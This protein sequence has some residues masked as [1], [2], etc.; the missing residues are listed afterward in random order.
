MLSWLAGREMVR[1][2]WQFTRYGLMVALVTVA[3]SMP[4]LWIR[5]FLLA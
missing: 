3:V 2:F 5:Y 4:Y 1:R